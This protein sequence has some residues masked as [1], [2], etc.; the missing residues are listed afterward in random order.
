MS[1]I[2]TFENP[3]GSPYSPMNDLPGARA[4][5]EARAPQPVEPPL[6]EREL[7]TGY[8]EGPFSPPG[9]CPWCDRRRGWV[10]ERRKPKRAVQRKKRRPSGSKEYLPPQHEVFCGF[11]GIVSPPIEP[12][13]FAAFRK[14]PEF[15]AA[16]IAMNPD[17]P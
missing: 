9:I 7:Q 6:D 16:L 4:P 5:E 8:A 2:L 1:Q 12:V 15:A 10:A 14:T 17:P 11:C 13:P 3:L